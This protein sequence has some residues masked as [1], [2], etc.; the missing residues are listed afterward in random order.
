MISFFI[1]IRH[2]TIA[3][4]TR[5]DARMAS[6]GPRDTVSGASERSRGTG[7]RATAMSSRY[8]LAVFRKFRIT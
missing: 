7:P 4:E 1:G 5:S 6:E 2:A 3:G 8:V